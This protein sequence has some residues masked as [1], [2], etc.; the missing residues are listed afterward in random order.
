VLPADECL[1]GKQAPRP[2][3]YLGLVVKTQATAINGLPKGQ[4][5]PR[6]FTD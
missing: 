1:Y 2:K 4:L 3:V 6:A 5:S